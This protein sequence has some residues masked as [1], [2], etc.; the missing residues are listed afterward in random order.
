MTGKELIVYILQHDLENEEVI[1]DGH[2]VGYLT[3]EEF[4]KKG[5]VGIETVKAWV[6]LGMVESAKIGNETFITVDSALR[7]I[8]DRHIYE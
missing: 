7:C 1:K 6:D 3:V 8:F 4:A 5:F 2:I